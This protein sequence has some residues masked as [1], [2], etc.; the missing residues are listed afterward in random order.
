MLT[1]ALQRNGKH[2]AGLS[3]ILAF[4]VVLSWQQSEMIRFVQDDSCGW[5][6][7]FGFCELQLWICHSNNSL[8]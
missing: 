8:R 2:D 4:L 1:A 5:M 7:E 6:L 3:N